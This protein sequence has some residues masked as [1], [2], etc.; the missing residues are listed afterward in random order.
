LVEGGADGGL[1]QLLKQGA[2]RRSL[3]RIG[4]CS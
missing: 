2:D 1:G 3:A 4:Q